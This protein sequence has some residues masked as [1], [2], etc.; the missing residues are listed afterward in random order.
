M[1]SISP[2]PTFANPPQLPGRTVRLFQDNRWDSPSYTISLGNRAPNAEYSFSGEGMQDNATILAYNLPVGEVVTLTDNVSPRGNVC[3][4]G[5]CGRSVDLVGTGKT[6]SCNLMALGMNDCLSAYFWRK[7]DMNLG[8]IELYE[9][10]D[11][12]GARTVIFLSDWEPGTVHSIGNWFMNDTASSAKWQTLSDRQ[13]CRLY[14]HSDASGRSYANIIGWGDSK[15]DSNFVRSG[16]NDIVSAFRWD[17]IVP[18][19]EIIQPFTLSVTV[20]SSSSTA[21][22]AEHSI[23]NDSSSPQ[24]FDVTLSQADAETVTLTRTDTHHVGSSFSWGWSSST[25]AGGGVA[26]VADV[27]TKVSYEVK[28]SL[29]YDYTH[30]DS[31]STSSTKSRSLTLTEKFT[32]PPHTRTTGQIIARIGQIQPTTYQTSAQR[33]YD[34][35]VNGSSYDQATGWYMRTEMV[36]GEIAGGLHCRTDLTVSS[37]ALALH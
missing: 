34:V 19:K 7:V 23:M 25:E 2:L 3:D 6:E 22:T 35:Q 10:T 17:P 9:H 11:Y 14:E 1:P 37:D 36:T 18:K 28:I 30:S 20:D 33:W 27:K 4:L 29:Q 26:G 5:G 16:F 15:E 31:T 24:E 21:F 32:A 8:A 13:I 12:N